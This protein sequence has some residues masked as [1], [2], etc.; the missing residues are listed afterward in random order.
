MEARSIDERPTIVDSR[1]RFG[2][3]EVDTVLGKQGTGVLVI[4]AE[5]K[6]RL[7]W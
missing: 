7:I 1:E 5:R 4:L 2:D 3:W 6:S